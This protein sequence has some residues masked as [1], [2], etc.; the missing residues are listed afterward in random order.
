MSYKGVTR[1]VKITRRF[2]GL[3]F[4][5]KIW[6]TF[7]SHDFV[8]DIQKQRTYFPIIL[9]SLNTTFCNDLLE[10]DHM[11]AWLSAK[12]V[13]T[14]WVGQVSLKLS[15]LLVWAAS[16]VLSLMLHLSLEGF[17]EVTYNPLA[18]WVK[19]RMTPSDRKKPRILNTK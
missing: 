3:L 10:A 15:T 2:R 18:R 6:L 19:T 14:F 4:I 13:I 1:T 9:L 17:F 7:S 16:F 12:T 11:I 8:F 5:L